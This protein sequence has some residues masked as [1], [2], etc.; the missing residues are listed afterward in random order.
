MPF[1]TDTCLLKD[2]TIHQDHSDCRGSTGAL[3]ELPAR[4]LYLFQI[5]VEV[6][7]SEV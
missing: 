3:Q 1:I 7:D 4:L 2:V 5:P 6:V